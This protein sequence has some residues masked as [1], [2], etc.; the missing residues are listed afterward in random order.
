MSF[1]QPWMLFALPAIALPILIHLIHRRRHRTVE[2]GAMMF[3]LQ[4]ARMSKGYQRLRHILLLILRTLAVAGLIFG[5][6]RPIAGGWLG[7]LGGGRPDSVIVLLDRSAS[8]AETVPGTG[9]SKLTVGVRRLVEALGNV[10]AN[11]WAFVDSVGGRVTGLDSPA[12]LADLPVAVETSAGA[13]LPGML[14]AAVDYLEVNSSGRAEIWICSDGRL[15]DWRPEDGRWPALRESLLAMPAGVRVNVLAFD[16]RPPENLAIRVEKVERV[17]GT[18]RAEL[19]LDLRITAEE[20][21]DASVPVAV[22]MG[23]ARSI[24]RV[25]MK[26]REALLEGHRMPL[27]EAEGSGWGFVELGDDGGPLDNRF[28]FTYGEAVTLETFVVAE[29]AAVADVLRIAAESP[30]RDDAS[31]AAEVLRPE[32]ASPLDLEGVSLLLWQAPLPEDDGIA[33]EIERFVAAGGRAIFLPPETPLGAELFGCSWGHTAELGS[34]EEPAS[35]TFWRGESDLLRHGD[36]GTPLPVADTIVRRTTGLAGDFTPLSSFAGGET[37]LARA[38]TGRG[39]AYFLTALPKETESNLASQG[40]VL[41]AL[42]HRAL[43]AA[44]AEAGSRSQQEAGRFDGSLDDWTSAGGTPEDALLAERFHHAGVVTD[45]ERFVALNRSAAEDRPEV[46]AEERLGSML[47]DVDVSLVAGA[48]G[49]A[50]L[51]EEVWRLFLI[52]MLVALFG[53]ALLC[54]GESSGEAQKT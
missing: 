48:A 30:L 41:F 18:E 25:E 6:G 5:L 36:G 16:E 31:W 50:S 44:V 53:E 33:A 14:E 46:L 43:A 27:D 45:G 35:P 12:D 34:A 15:A 22:D 37:F 9:E 17:R 42:L 51:I 8:M 28:Y 21:R 7:G 13:D 11:G 4:G 39:G 3:L 19:A 52:A 26:G 1:L 29:D 10:E 40:V 38:P 32:D 54:I 2:W 49:E 47:Q 23:G 24:V 20:E